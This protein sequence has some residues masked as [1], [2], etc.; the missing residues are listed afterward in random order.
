MN[1]KWIN[2]LKIILKV[3]LE[4]IVIDLMNKLY[5]NKLIT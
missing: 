2:L 4:F 3:I 5:S 1:N